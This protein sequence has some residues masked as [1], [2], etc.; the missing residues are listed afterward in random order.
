MFKKIIPF[1]V[2]LLVGYTPLALSMG[3]KAKS[4]DWLNTS[5][6]L[7]ELKNTY[8]INVAYKFLIQLILADRFNN[9][10]TAQNFL[11]K[12]QPDLKEDILQEACIKENPQIIRAI[13]ESGRSLDLIIQGRH[14]APLHIAALEN[15]LAIGRCLIDEGANVNIQSDAYLDN[16]TPL[17]LAAEDGHKDF[18]KLLIEHQVDVNAQAKDGF[19]ALHT[20][21]LEGHTD[22][23]RL[24]LEHGAR[25]DMTTNENFT[26]LAYAYDMNNTEIIELF[27][28]NI[29]YQAIEEKMLAIFDDLNEGQPQCQTQNPKKKNRR[30]KKKSTHN[31][32]DVSIQ[33]SNIDSA[34]NNTIAQ[35]ATTEQS[36]A[37]DLTPQNN[38]AAI[39]ESSPQ[40]NITKQKENPYSTQPAQIQ[41]NAQHYYKILQDRKLKWPIAM[42][43][44]T[45]K[46]I[47]GH[48]KQLHNWPN[49][50]L[51]IKKLKDGNGMYR[52]RSG[53]YRI[54]FTVDQNNRV[55]YVHKISLR[56]AAY[57]KH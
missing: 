27:T 25:I 17:L 57:K 52:L 19:T 7:S 32:A 41:R 54:L 16:I 11:R 37:P 18:V 10:Q 8:Q 21:C 15:K 55:I 9:T 2:M 13:K 22:I 20:A 46:L 5:L 4:S 3:K 40:I 45:E 12:L 48:M 31:A 28:K 43:P 34:P 35:D 51:D 39:T 29:D 49:T 56:K 1:L 30:R 44:K 42:H 38:T 6:Q 47:I 50:D 36:I 33:N 53:M 24:L 14:C 26:A 23:V